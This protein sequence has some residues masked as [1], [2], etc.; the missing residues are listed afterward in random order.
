MS[1]RTSGEAL[2]TVAHTVAIPAVPTSFVY[3]DLI[4]HIQAI[5][6]QTIEITKFIDEGQKTELK[7]RSL[8]IVDPYGNSVVN[9]HMDHEVIDS[10]L[11]KFKRDYVPKFLKK[12]I[13]FGK[14][15]GNSISLLTDDELT[16]TVSKYKDGHPFITYGEVPVWIGDYK[17]SSARLI[18][19]RCLITDNIEK[20]KIQLKNEKQIAN[21]ELKSLIINQNTKPN[22]RSWH[23]GKVLKLEDT[24][25][26]YQLYQDN[27]IIMAKFISEK[28][29]D[30]FCSFNFT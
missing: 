3:K 19:L 6:Q 20:I 23:E 4:Y 11:K 2:F 14:K 10:L 17:C 22:K 12:W 9:T 27:C 7:S 1:N 29:N 30:N 26:S 21:I 25:M 24:I 13:K 18:K 28:V 15:N 16:S 8:T 5:Q